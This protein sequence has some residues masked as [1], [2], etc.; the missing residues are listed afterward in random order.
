MKSPGRRLRELFERDGVTIA[1]GAVDVL[2][3]RVFK[4]VGYEMIW[5]GGFM[6]SASQLG[7]ADANVIGLTEHSAY[8]RNLALS[9]GLPVLVDVDNAY[10]S[11]INV[12]RT[13]REMEAAGAAGVV[14]EDQVF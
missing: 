7:W 1:P 6:S 10:G 5:A 12:I 3:G 4:R 2:S 13:V 9:T 11:A 8:V 14:I